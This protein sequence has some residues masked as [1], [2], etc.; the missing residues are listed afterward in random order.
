MI[1][2]DPVGLFSWN[3]QWR[4]DAPGETATVMLG[5]FVEPG[6]IETPVFPLRFSASRSG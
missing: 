6:A 4:G 2:F 5:W 1:T 3:F